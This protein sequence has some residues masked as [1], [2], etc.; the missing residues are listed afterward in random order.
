MVAVRGRAG[1]S[2][3][4][5]PDGPRGA[6]GFM[7]PM[8]PKGKAGADAGADVPDEPLGAEAGAGAGAGAGSK[9]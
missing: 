9:S 5:L 3:L 6:K 2:E 7:P 8:N 1:A 4:R